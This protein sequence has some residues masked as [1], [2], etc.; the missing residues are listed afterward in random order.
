MKTIFS[1]FGVAL[2]SSTSLVSHTYA[3]SSEGDFEEIIVTVNRRE[4]PKSNI[5]SSISIIT[6]EDIIKSQTVFIQDILQNIPGISLNQNGS[7][8]G[9]SSIR[10]R[11][12]S[13]SQTV[14][15]INGVQIN[16]VSSPGGGFNF[17]NL[18]PNGIERVEVLRGPQSILY[19]SDAIGGVINIITRSGGDGLG[20]NA[21]LEGGSFNTFRGGASL[22]GGTERINFN[23]SAS[24]IT[25]DGISK[26]DEND[27]NTEKDGYEN[28]TLRGKITAK[29]SDVISGEIL[30]NYSDSENNFD[31][32]GPVD[33]D[34][35]EMTEDFMIAGRTHIDLLDGRFKNSLSLEYSKTDRRNLNNGVAGFMADGARLNLDYLGLYKA[36]EYVDISFGAQ[37]EETKASSISEQKFNIDSLFSELSFQGIAGLT[38]TGGLRYD[39]H[40]QFG[41]TTSL[42]FTSSYQIADSGTR[43]FATWGEGFKAPSIFQLTFICGFC[44]LTEP[45]ANL[46]PEE[47][48]GWDVGIEQSFQDGDLTFTATY[49]EQNITNLINFDFSVGFGNIDAVKSKGIELSFE[50]EL[51]AQITVS[52]NYTYTNT[53][54]RNTGEKLE[55]IPA[56]AAFAQIAWQPRD[57]LSLIASLTYNGKELPRGFS[58]GVDG[59]VRFDIRASYD[60]TEQIAVYGR[61]DNLFDKE[62]QQ[63]AGFGTA[64]RS[65]YVGIR[66]NF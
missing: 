66:T 59:W 24:A 30:F 42:R 52:G 25:S 10:I 27:G 8:G 56:N 31:G 63:I 55:R 39:T 34:N 33:A 15:L 29:A 38:L 48:E 54:D 43:L 23:I 12:A 22:R 37:H 58:A 44:G 13:S 50:A 47:S 41:D 7:I 3:A 2:L 26:A 60:I 6:N 49:F 62:Y 51:M 5:G 57:D 21:F 11:G 40:S 17:A 65:A 61:V 45:N 20:G 1:A 53:V 16:D 19:G 64:D 18:D 28:I 32:F 36:N 46:K 35:V 9:V 14:I 4:Q